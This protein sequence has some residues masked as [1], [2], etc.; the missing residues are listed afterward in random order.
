MATTGLSARRTVEGHG[1]KQPEK[2]MGY[3]GRIDKPLLAEAGFSRK[4]NPKMY[5]CGPTPFV[6]NVSRLLVE[7][8]HDPLTVRTERLGPTGG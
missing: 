5:V 8:G 7:L 3:R 4:Q 1:R 6:E 2:W